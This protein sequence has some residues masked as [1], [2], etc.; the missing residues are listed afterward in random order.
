MKDI[1]AKLQLAL[2]D[3]KIRKKIIFTF[4]MIT[5]FRIFTYLPVSVVDLGELR[6]LFGSS[7]FFFLL[8]IFS[9]GTLINFSVMALGLGPYINAITKKL[10]SFPPE[11]I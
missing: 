8:D 3:T 11:K 9:G 4:A 10:I 7:Q 6:K 5:L 1:L 2:K